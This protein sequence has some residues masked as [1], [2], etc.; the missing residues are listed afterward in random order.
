MAVYDVHEDVTACRSCL[1][2]AVDTIEIV[3]EEVE[4]KVHSGKPIISHGRPSDSI[5]SFANEKYDT[6]VLAVC[7]Q[8]TSNNS[9]SEEATDLIFPDGPAIHV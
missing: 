4:V 1:H 8:N 7:F 6:V 5:F 2:H 9:F 3:T